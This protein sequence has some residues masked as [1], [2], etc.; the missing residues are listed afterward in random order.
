[1]VKPK[2]IFSEEIKAIRKIAL[3]LEE[4]LSNVQK[5]SREREG[6]VR[7]L[8]G[9]LEKVS[10]KAEVLQE[11]S[12]LVGLDL[13]ADEVLSLIMDSILKLMKTDAGSI[14]LLD[15]S[16]ERL[17]FK[18]AK[19]DKATEVKKFDIKV[20]EG[21]AGWV[22]QNNQ[23]VIAPHPKKD[24]RFKR[25][26]AEKIGYI[27]Y[28]ILCAPLVLRKR[29]IGV[30][31]LINTLEKKC[32]TK[33]DEDLLVSIN[34]QI[35]IV[36]EN[37]NLF[38]ALVRKMSE[39]TVLSEVSKTVNSTISLDNVLDLSMRLV[40][41]VMRVE[42]S[43]LLLLDKE[44]NELVF[45]VALGKKGEA[46]KEIRVPIGKG[47][48]GW[49]AE[50]GEP[51]YIK[52]VDGDERF[53]KEADKLSGFITKSI[54]CVPLK[55]KDRLIG[56]AQ[57]INPIGGQEVSQDDIELFST[58]GSQMAIA[59][60]NASLYKDLEELFFSTISTLVATIDAKDPYT[61]GHSQRVM[62]YSV[63]VAEELGQSKEE[64][65]GVK[66]SSLLHDIGK[67]GVDEKILRK[68]GRLT[69]DEFS[70]IKT[71]PGLGA[72]IV[73]HIKQLM[74]VSPGIRHHHER[75][76]G[77]GYPTGLAANMIPLSARIIAVADTYDAMT[78]DRPYR[79][80]LETKVALAEIEKFSG[81]QFD[82]TCA[83]AFL[84][85]H[86]KG[87]IIIGSKMF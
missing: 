75:Y 30:V 53:F 46:I 5:R 63:A 42:A 33:D 87:R 84:Q 55:V 73:S 72:D 8:Y 71:H 50:T 29:V 61:H 38:S 86:K 11:I 1:M 24:K 54:I 83:D 80:G 64:I 81:I 47:V 15:K 43:S 34:N 31:E 9:C 69:D 68:T 82:R 22:A 21:I 44:K 7:L 56:V 35:A 76:D 65:K 3:S 85:A 6:R 37:A 17:T 59:L 12:D 18:I 77:Q 4:D 10:L 27:P 66:L 32:F 62:E 36:I 16:G 49:V 79:Q 60:E 51:L 41:Q 25:D 14:L 13:E 74:A 70:V 39:K 23:S 48:A 52:D 57:A 58:I 78:S 45:Q 26:I 20:G 67:I 19:G 28:N 2:T 40:K